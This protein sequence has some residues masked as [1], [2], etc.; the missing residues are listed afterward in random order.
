MYWPIGAPRIFAAKFINTLQEAEVSDDGLDKDLSVQETPPKAIQLRD[1]GTD[2]ETQHQT[3]GKT[4][5]AAGRREGQ[6]EVDGEIKDLKVARNGQLFAVITSSA[7]TVWQIRPQVVLAAI[8]RSPQSI[9]TYGGNIGLLVRPD[10]AIFVVQTAEGYLITYSLTTDPTARVYKTQYLQ[11]AASYH[12]RRSQGHSQSISA[13]DQ[14]SWTAR[15]G[16]GVREVNIKFRMVIKVD[17][18]IVKALAL[19]QELVVATAKPAAI[20]CIR[21]SP[22]SGGSQTRTELLSKMPWVSKKT[23]IVDMSH[24]R[25]MNLSTWCATDGR[26]YAVQRNLATLK[27]GDSRKLFRG[28]CFHSPVSDASSATTAAIN[29][30]FSLIAVA[31][32]NGH[33]SVY[34]VKDYAGNIPISHHLQPMVSESNTGKVTSLSYSADGY[35]LFAGYEKGW[36]TWSVYGKPGAN[37]FGA[38]SSVA[39]AQKDN[40]LAGVGSANWMSGGGE[41]L[42]TC[43]RDNRIWILEM[44][45]SALAGCFT[46]S[47]VSR[48]LLQTNTGLLVYRGYDSPD[49]VSISADSS[50][51]QQIPVPTDFLNDQW[52]IRATV[53]SSDGKYVAIAGRRG[54]A[55]YSIN[56]GRWKTFDNDFMENEFVV[57]GGMCWYRHILV[58]AVEANNAYELRLYSR[59]LA[60]DN[61]Q[62]LHIENVAA[63]VVLVDTCGNDSILA[64][65]HDN[66]LYHYVISSGPEMLQLILVGQITFH[67]IVRAP[68]RVRALSWILPDDQIRDGDPS[69]DVALAAVVFLVDGK[70][71]LLQPTPNE[72]GELRYDMRV[73]LTQVEYFALTRNDPN[74]GHIESLLDQDAYLPSEANTNSVN[75]G[76]G[77]RDSLWVFDGNQMRVWSEIQE[78]VRLAPTDSSFDL[79]STISVPVDFYPASVLLNKGLILGV[80]AEL[81]QRRD[82]AFAF[83]KLPIR[84]HLFLP[85]ILSHH[86]STLDSASA[87]HLSHH[88]QDLSYFAHA[89][90]V[91]L[92]NALDE[93]V[94]H[95]GPTENR[96]LPTV[97]SFLSSFPQYLDIL[98]QCTRKTEVRSW[99]TLFGYLPPPRELFEEALQRGAL[100]TAGGYLLVLHTFEDM[101]TSS[102]QSIRL[103]ARAKEENDWEL[104]KEL[105]RFLLAMDASGEFLRNALREVNLHTS[106]TNEIL[107]KDQSTGGRVLANGV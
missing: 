51:W 10:S 27:D 29:A 66:V 92:H 32:N 54:L 99:R 102:E 58:A 88:Y 44:A 33:I 57:R 47:N 89:L 13:R 96:L 98:V 4:Q 48:P 103:L 97:L 74:V 26:A 25:P 52:P 11:N 75:L 38:D 101:G 19:D 40:W 23:G 59:E 64:Y 85:Y 24:D 56:S 14:I 35:C 60:L 61:S 84:T 63:P 68:A 69:K 93:E 36:A 1:Q 43:R 53:I 31:C 5:S 65:T 45:R 95:G 100:K 21:W 20:Q 42:L 46:S 9:S 7:L 6:F 17:A 50:L 76:H 70:L 22:D 107:G 3:N 80:E 16:S 49:L 34:T 86:L 15:Q 67:G 90:E 2:S 83:Y 91:L 30:R 77:L 81:L 18:G 106:G 105:A 12:R 28:Y 82:I 55:H 8:V 87:L 94:D 79:P 72:E 62:I 73:L 39:K 37:S 41:I 104:S 78:V 71:V